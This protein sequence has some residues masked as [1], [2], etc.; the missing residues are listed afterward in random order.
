M[1]SHLPR[2][3]TEENYAQLHLLARV[4]IERGYCIEN[5]GSFPPLSFGDRY[6]VELEVYE[7]GLGFPVK[8]INEIDQFKNLRLRGLSEVL[9]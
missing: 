6:L 5:Y 9:H 3:N 2:V 4:I 1:Y 8:R 7:S